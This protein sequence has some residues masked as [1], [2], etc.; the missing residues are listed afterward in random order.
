MAITAGMP[1]GTGLNRFQA[2]VP[3]PLLRRRDRRAARGRAGDRAGDGRAAAGGGDLL[4]VPP[5]GVR[6]DRPR[7]LPERPAGRSSRVDRAGLVGEDGTSHQGMFTL[8][9]QRQIPNLVIA[10]PKDEQELRS[11]LRTALAQD[12][13]FALHYPRDPGFG[14]PPRAPEVLPIGRGEMLREGSDILIVGFGPIVGPGDGGRRRA[15]RRRLVGRRHQRPVREAARSRAHPRLGARQAARRDP[16]GERRDRRLRVGR[17]RAP[18]GGADRGPGLPR[19]G[20]ADRRDPRR[21]GSSTTA[22]WPTCAGSSGSTPPGS[23]RRSARRSRPSAWKRRPRRAA[24]RSPSTTPDGLAPDPLYVARAECQPAEWPPAAA[25]SRSAGGGLCHDRPVSAETIQ[26]GRPARRRLDQLLVERGLA[27]SRTRAQA[28]LLAGRV[29]VGEGDGA[30]RDRK[31]GDLVDPSISVVVEAPEPYVSRGGHKLAAALDAFAIDPSG[32]VCLD[33]GASTGGF[34]DVLLQR[35]AAA[36]LRRRRRA[37]PARRGAS[38]RPAGRVARADERADARAAASCPSRSSSPSSTS[39]SSR[40][41]SSSVRR[42]PASARRA[43]RSS[44]S[45]SPSSRPDARRSTGVSCAT[46]RSTS[47]SSAGSSPPPAS[48]AWPRSR[49]SPSPLLGPDGN[50]EFLLHLVVAGDGAT[51]TATR[52]AA[53]DR[54]TD[55]RLVE[56]A[57][58]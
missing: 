38:A 33:V 51:Q 39:R 48:S 50:R 27:E 47:R 32:L 53:L 19:R 28:L 56:V 22:R 15:R 35:G 7:R 21:T 31:P 26:A 20:A 57:A 54:L 58:G 25:A 36:R 37:R 8:P 43:G 24:A 23:R 46:R 17:P 49:R 1:T 12:H 29:R 11:L 34:T 18:R 14:V 55:E 6:P 30:R 42:R 10:S 40:C 9:A 5:A 44:R 13:P 3:G 41:A 16:R 4:D 52:L 45:S 2:G